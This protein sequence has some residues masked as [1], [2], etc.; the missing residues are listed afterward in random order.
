[1]IREYAVIDTMDERITLEITVILVFTVMFL[2]IAHSMWDYLHVETGVLTSFQVLSLLDLTV[3][4]VMSLSALWKYVELNDIMREQAD[5]LV[6]ARH[7]L[8]T[9][10][11]KLMDMTDAELQLVL[12]SQS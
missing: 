12:A 1:M 9:P 7:G 4:G 5:I 6:N 11:S 3:L 8:L 10:E 2:T